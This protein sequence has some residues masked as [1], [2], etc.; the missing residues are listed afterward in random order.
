MS[1]KEWPTLDKIWEQL[2]RHEKK[3]LGTIE[4]I[5]KSAEGLEI[6]MFKATNPDVP[7][8]DK[9]IIVTLAGEHGDEVTGPTMHMML[10]DWLAS[11]GGTE[12]L[13]TQVVMVIP[14]INVDG[15]TQCVG[16]TS[17]DVDL[18][19]GFS[20]EGPPVSAEARAVWEVIER[21]IPDAFVNV[22]GGRFDELRHALLSKT[23]TSFHPEIAEMMDL[24]ADEEGWPQGRNTEFEVFPAPGDLLSREDRPGRPAVPFS[25]NMSYTAKKYHTLSCLMHVDDEREGLPRLKK[26]LQIGSSRWPTEYYRGYPNRIMKYQGVGLLSACGKTAA[27]R[28]ASRAELRENSDGLFL[29]SQPCRPGTDILVLHRRTKPFIRH[30]AGIR[31]RI[32]KGSK[33]RQVI[34]NEQEMKLSEDHGYFSWDDPRWT[35]VQVNILQGWAE[36]STRARAGDTIPSDL[37]FVMVKYDPS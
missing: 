26:L 28:R 10:L 12:V 37:A 21:Y 5:G 16:F 23:V 3:G 2:H 19:V 29:L 17:E 1:K 14:C 25:S 15:F 35:V 7:D 22:H 11:D 13:R 20:L 4:V 9:E 36:G 18:F 31:F 24:A 34:F 6:P 32:P 30:G 8:D 27:Q 33:I